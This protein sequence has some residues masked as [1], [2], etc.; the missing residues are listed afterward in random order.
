[1]EWLNVTGERDFAYG[2][3]KIFGWRAERDDNIYLVGCEI[4]CETSFA[5]H[6]YTY[7]WEVNLRTGEV[8]PLNEGAEN[9]QA[10]AERS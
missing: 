2:E 6:S 9:I 7:E 1:V 5:T 10:V 8:V 3:W 4:R